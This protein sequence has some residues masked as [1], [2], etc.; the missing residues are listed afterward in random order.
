MYTETVYSVIPRPV[1]IPV[2]SRASAHGCSQLKHQK[3]RVG[4]YTKE[5]L[6]WSNY[7][8][9]AWSWCRNAE[10]R[11]R[12]T[13]VR[14]QREAEQRRHNL[15]L[16]SVGQ[17][18]VVASSGNH[19]LLNSLTAPVSWLI[20]KYSDTIEQRMIPGGS[21]D[22]RLTKVGTQSSSIIISLPTSLS[23]VHSHMPL[24]GY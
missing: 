6:E 1:L 13:R 15:I 8:R 12:L 17:P 19:P 23:C 11:R 14:V 22:E 10:M 16:A 5:V 4:G 18:L 21:N 20:Y 24:Y 2:L 7:L 3:L 9:H